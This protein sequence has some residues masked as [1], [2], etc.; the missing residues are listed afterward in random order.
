MRHF[1]IYW[2]HKYVIMSFLL[3]SQMTSLSPSMALS[4]F[5]FFFALSNILLP[6]SSQVPI[7]AYMV[8]MGRRDRRH[9][10]GKFI[11]AFTIIIVNSTIDST[12]ALR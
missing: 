10:D 4:F 2:H 6:R 5:S 7:F 11:H 1:E 3:H 8:D 12:F 9:A